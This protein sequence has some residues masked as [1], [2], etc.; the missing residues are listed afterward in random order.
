MPSPGGL[1]YM[2]V[3]REFYVH[4][5]SGSSRVKYLALHKVSCVG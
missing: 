1:R 3:R 5:K 2:S 4:L